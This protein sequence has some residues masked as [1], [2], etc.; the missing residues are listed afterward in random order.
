MIRTRQL[1]PCPDE[2]PS[3]MYAFMVECWHEIPSRRPTF[4]GVYLFTC[5][6]TCLLV[7]LFTCLLVYLFTCL[8]VYLFT[9]LLARKDFDESML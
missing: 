6:F 1:L 2:C 7:Y 9:C 5:L 4:T 8:L 3:R